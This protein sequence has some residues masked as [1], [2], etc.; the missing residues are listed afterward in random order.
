MELERL[1]SSKGRIRV[2]R[3]LLRE[4][5]VNIS[6]LIRETGLHHRLVVKHLEELKRMGLV[7][8]RRYG[9]LRIYEANLQD[10]RVSALRELLK[11]LESILG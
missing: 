5:Q 1:L 6:R 8:E 9:R 4:G 2:L 7:E 3:I 11:T 10:P